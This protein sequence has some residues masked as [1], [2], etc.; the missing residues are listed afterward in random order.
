MRGA[1]TSTTQPNN[2]KNFKDRKRHY[3]FPS[4]VLESNP[5]FRLRNFLVAQLEA[6]ACHGKFQPKW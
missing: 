6:S 5:L 2:W 1:G 3:F 4:L